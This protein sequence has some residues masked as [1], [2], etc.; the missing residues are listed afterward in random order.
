MHTLC[1]RN[2]R[3]YNVELNNASF[4]KKIVYNSLKRKRI[5]SAGVYVPSVVNIRLDYFTFDHVL[6]NWDCNPE[7]FISTEKNKSRIIYK[8]KDGVEIT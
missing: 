1:Y 7:R 3:D 6:N 8:N 4:V 5:E 2:L